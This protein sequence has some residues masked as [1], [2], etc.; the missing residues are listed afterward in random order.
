MSS[1]NGD[2]LDFSGKA[3]LITGAAT[4]PGAA[5]PFFTAGERAAGDVRG[6]RTRTDSTGGLRLGG[7]DGDANRV[8]E[9]PGIHVPP[10]IEGT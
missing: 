7:P 2:V 1:A 6:P 8:Q 9:R 5:F 10:D 4:G 3:V